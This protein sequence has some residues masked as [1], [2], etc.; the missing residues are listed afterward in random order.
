MSLLTLIAQAT[1]G[2]TDLTSLGTAGMMA[3]M[4]LWERSTSRTREEQLNATHD[5]IVGDRVQLDALV[6]L[7]RQNTQAMTR[8]AS[9]IESN[10]KEIA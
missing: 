8:L 5:R 9:L 1:P 3:A 2:L 4:W 6:E 7:V 10:R